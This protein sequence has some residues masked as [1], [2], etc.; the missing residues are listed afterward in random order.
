MFSNLEQSQDLN[1]AYRNAFE[2][3]PAQIEKQVDSYL[4]AGTFGT[5]DVTGRALNP[6]H[7]FRVEDADQDD[8]RLAQADLLLASGS[9]AAEAAYNGLHGPAAA[10]GLGLVALKAQKKDEA[11]RLFQSAI[12]SADA[13]ARAWYEAGVLEADAAKATADLNKAAQLNPRWAAPQYQLAQRDPD[14]DR[15]AILLSRACSLAPR[16]AEYW[17]ELAETYMQANH[18]PEAQKAWGGAENAAANDQERQ[19]I[20]QVRL[21]V[22][23]Q[24]ADFEAAERKRIADEKAADLARVKDQSMAE[25][26]A[27]EAAARQRLNPN[28]AAPPQPMQWMDVPEATARIEGTLLRLDCLGQ[29]ARLAILKPDGKTTVQLLVRESS[30]I[31]LLNGDKMPACGPQKP[32]R[33]VSVGY[34]PRV[35]K[36]L[37]TAGDVASIE[38]R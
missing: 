7:D 8:G 12:T 32:P 24:R 33:T 11:R 37:G 5:T 38:F 27:A 15:K 29:Q 26:H 22:E 6:A 1:P 9:S 19:H 10:T 31:I 20:R 34:A 18:F 16:N 25:I 4:A 3:T 2:K 28:G 21:D 35:D 36:K 17:R 14:L 30:Q 23:K 13:G